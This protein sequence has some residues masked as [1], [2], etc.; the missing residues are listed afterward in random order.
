[1]GGRRKQEVEIRNWE[2]GEQEG[3][4]WVFCFVCFLSKY[5]YESNFTTCGPPGFSGLGAFTRKK[6]LCFWVDLFPSNQVK[7]RASTVGYHLDC[8]ALASGQLLP[9]LPISGRINR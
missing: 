4:F 9:S 8:V 3:D 1:M 7:S 6:S 5:E 2:K